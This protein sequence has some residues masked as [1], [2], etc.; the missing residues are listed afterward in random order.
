[1]TQFGIGLREAETTAKTKRE[2]KSVKVSRRS[3]SDANLGQYT[4]YGMSG[5]RLCTLRHCDNLDRVIRTRWKLDRS[6]NIGGSNKSVS[7]TIKWLRHTSRNWLMFWLHK[8]WKIGG[9]RYRGTDRF[10]EPAYNY[11]GHLW[12]PMEVGEVQTGVQEVDQVAEEHAISDGE[13][14]RL[15]FRVWPVGFMIRWNHFAGYQPQYAVP[16][17]QTLGHCRAGLGNL[18]N[19]NS[20]YLI[21]IS[22]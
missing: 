15:N 7:R 22:E 17:Q 4:P 2:T 13:S 19:T 10:R 1:M 14:E 3:Q 8:N 16:P 6:Y 12:F 11:L 18:F 5:C 9:T 20:Q 21:S